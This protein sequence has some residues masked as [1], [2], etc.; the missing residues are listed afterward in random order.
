MKNKQYNLC[1]YG[2]LAVLV[3]FHI[4]MVKSLLSS[5]FFLFPAIWL[6]LILIIMG[7]LPRMHTPG[8]IS[9]QGAALGYAFSGAVIFCAAS[10]LTGLALG[11]LSATPYDN[12]PAG[13]LYN[14]ISIVPACVAGEMIRA[15]SLGTVFRKKKNSMIQAILITILFALLEINYRKMTTLYGVSEITIFAARDV[16]PVFLKNMLLSVFVYFGGAKSGI[17]FSLGITLFKRIFPFLPDLPWL[18]ESALGIVCPILYASFLTERYH[19][20]L[21]ERPG[22][23]EGS[24]FFYGCGLA[25]AV[26]FSWFVVGVFPVYPSIVL[27]GSMEPQ[28]MPGDAILIRKMMEEKE[29]Y[30]LK[31]GDVINF[32][33]DNITITHRIAEVIKDE[34]GNV[35]FRTKGDNNDSPDNEI[36]SPNDINGTLINVVPKIGIPVLILKSGEPVPEGVE[37]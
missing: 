6:A 24:T 33:R 37:N 15:Y 5:P 8:Q 19:L 36:V 2:L 3:V 10:Y 14:L 30:Q 22:K 35:T 12:S 32:K 16:I 23:E 25:A 26:L 28:I 4:P 34:S 13:I 27:T 20:F 18:A 9:F 11:K 21:G 7:F 17:I 1:M 31:T 29:V